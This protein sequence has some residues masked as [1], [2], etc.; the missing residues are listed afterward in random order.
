MNMIDP[1]FI[2][3][4]ICTDCVAGMKQ[5][6][7]CCIPFT[8]TS[9]PYD[10]LRDY[11][12]HKFNFEA[13]AAELWRITMQG[14]V[15]VWVVGEQ[16]RKGSESGTAAR[17]KLHFLD[18]GFSVST[19]IMAIKRGQF[20]HGVRYPACFD[21]AF[22]MSKGRPRHVNIIRDKPNRCVGARPKRRARR[23]DGIMVSKSPPPGWSVG[24]FGER[25]NVWFYDVG[26]KKTTKDSFAHDHPAMMPEKMAED[27][28]LSWSRPGDI[29][30][31]PMCGAGTTLKMALLNNR[32]YLGMEIYQPYVDIAKKRLKLARNEHVRRLDMEFFGD[33]KTA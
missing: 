6:P 10:N 15:V 25:I 31:D 29:V 5:L 22:V 17:Q 20:S 8:L 14:G 33:Q 21:Y 13:V 2:N 18:L 24:E 32:K 28:V 11:G 16:I 1:Q 4:I 30:F 19:M 9:P 12:G 7:D 23:A 26:W 3:R 27:H